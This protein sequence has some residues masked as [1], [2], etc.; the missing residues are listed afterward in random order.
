MIFFSADTTVKTRTVGKFE[1]NNGQK[2]L[3]LSRFDWDPII[4]NMKVY[5]T[6]I[7]PDPELSKC[8]VSYITSKILYAEIRID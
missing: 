5:A 2:H 8:S 3:R 1:I 4:G 7:L 6:G